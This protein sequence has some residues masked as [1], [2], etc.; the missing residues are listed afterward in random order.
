MKTARF[1]KMAAWI[2]SLTLMAACSSS[3][4]LGRHSGGMQNNES[5]PKRGKASKTEQTAKKNNKNEQAA[6][7]PTDSTA[8]GPINQQEL[9][10]QMDENFQTGHFITSKIKFS[11][12]VG[13]RQMT[14]TGNLKMKRDDVIRL[15]LMAF[16]FV[17]AGRLEF[18]KDYVLIVD[19]INKQFLKVPYAQ[20]D[21]M[22]N[23]N[24]DFYTLQAL[25]WNELYQP[26][27]SRMKDSRKKELNSEQGLGDDVIFSYN[28]GRLSYRWLTEGRNARIKMT[29]IMYSDNIRGDHQLNWDYEDFKPL[30]RKFFPTTHKVTFTMPDKEVK[31]DMK[32]SY[33]G[34]DEDWETRTQLSGKYRQMPVDDILRR[35]MSL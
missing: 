8:K 4:S 18:T 11:V 32:L 19:R 33:I 3:S 13:N 10:K 28:E 35:F 16:G 6:Q 30:E 23:S 17:E 21:F 2:V 27:R 12:E 5:A 9:L 1:I 24:I 20:L 7:N 25:F 26:G 15:Q 14:L 34:K 31:F 22:R 29:N